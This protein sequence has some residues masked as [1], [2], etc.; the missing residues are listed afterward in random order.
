MMEE[1]RE[2]AAGDMVRPRIYQLMVR[3]F[4]NTNLTRKVDGTLA[5]NG[6]G[7]FVDIDAT[8]LEAL[9]GMGFTHVWLTGVLE[10]A[11]GTSFVDRPADDP[12]ILKGKAGSPYAIKD[13]FD[14]CPDYAV[15]PARRLVEFRGLLKRCEAAELRTIIDFVPNHVARS[16][17]SDVMPNLSFGRKDR[18]DRFFDRDNNFYYLGGIHPGGGP[19]LKLPAGNQPGCDGLFEQE[20]EVG[21]VTG[22][23]VVSW[24]PA[25][26]DWYETVKLNYGHDFTTG[27]DT[28]HLPGPD[29]HPGTVPDTWR[30]M[31]AVLEFWQELGV[32]GFRVDMAHMVPMEFWKWV[33]RRAR[34]REEQVFFMAEAYDGDPAKLTDE[35]VVG[36]LL[37]S[38]F[39]GVYDGPLYHR[40]Q[41]IYEGQ[42]WANDIDELVWAI[43][44][45]HA[46]VRYGE[47]HDEVRLA[48]PQRWGGLGSK[49]GRAVSAIAFGIGGGP[50]MLYNGQEVGEPAIGAEGFSGDDGR[51]SIFDYGALP[52][53]AKW[54]NG[55]RYDGGKLSME[56]REL[57]EWYG[58][59]M[60]LCGEPG[61]ERGWFY[62][63]NHA[64]LENPNFGR[65]GLETTSGHWLYVFLRSERRP[66]GQT[67]LVVVNMH[68]TASM[69]GVR[70][71]VPEHALGWLGMRRER[72]L[73][74]DR[75]MTDWEGEAERGQ[76]PTQGLALPKLEACSALF[77]EL[78]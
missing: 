43:D 24:D 21:R 75:L 9:R 67:F 2:S 48:N 6:C 19:P 46:M 42:K 22:N 54:V 53:L 18:T 50:V 66:G 23:N 61:F 14:V 17:H 55:H 28:S 15:D 51:S 5:E 71:R 27:R 3:H 63:L 45:L 29:G 64:N 57:R 11:S 1:Q 16:Y 76:L 65:V 49:V 40:L 4:G 78:G 13:Y 56:Q 74:R 31:D 62:G 72:V 7:K 77:L 68:G 41:A 39:E 35:D 37:K 25:I 69:E 20:K 59:L 8:A 30:K 34:K 36:A 32:G 10:Q 26:C 70:V 47:N 60:R 73:F 44:R 38:G 58:K 12:D 33:I 52:E